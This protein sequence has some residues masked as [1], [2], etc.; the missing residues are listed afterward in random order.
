MQ[1][2][3]NILVVDNTMTTLM[4]LLALLSTQGF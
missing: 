4:M 3:G 2:T 1:L